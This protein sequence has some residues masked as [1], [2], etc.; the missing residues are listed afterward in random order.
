MKSSARRRARPESKIA[1][2]MSIAA[3][4]SHTDGSA[5]PPR[6][7]RIGMPLTVTA[8]R[9]RTTSAAPGIG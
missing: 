6:A 5:K 8:V 2:A 3:S 4:T 9:P 1:R 7:S